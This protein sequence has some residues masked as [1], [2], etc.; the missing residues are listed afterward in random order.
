MSH[1]RTTTL[2]GVTV[3]ALERGKVNALNPSVVHELD[4]RLDE[5]ETNDAARALVLTGTG[6]FFTF[7]FDIQE[8]LSYPKAEFTRFLI[9]VRRHLVFRGNLGESAEDRD[10]P[11]SAV[12]DPCRERFADEATARTPLRDLRHSMAY[13]PPKAP[14]GA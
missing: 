10:P 11:V 3:I 5:I 2:D 12:R 7:G 8:F 9:G 13:G 6:K 14:R 1:T 4:G